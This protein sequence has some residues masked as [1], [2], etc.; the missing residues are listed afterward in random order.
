MDV[1]VRQ[2]VGDPFSRRSHAIWHCLEIADSGDPRERINR[3]YLSRFLRFTPPSLWKVMVSLM[4]PEYDTVIRVPF[5]IL[6]AAV[7]A[8]PA[9]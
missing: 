2:K 3:P 8:N 5:R 1:Y 9:G 6:F 7:M 4:A